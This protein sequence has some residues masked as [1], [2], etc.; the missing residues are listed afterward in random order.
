[1][2]AGKDSKGVKG[3]R[4]G[5]LGGGGGS[6][7]E[8]GFGG[9]TGERVQKR[10]PKGLGKECRWVVDKARCTLLE[11]SLGM[12]S[13][14]SSEDSNKGCRQTSTTPHNIIPG[15][16][17]PL[18]VGQ[19]MVQPQLWQA[20]QLWRTLQQHPAR[21]SSTAVSKKRKGKDG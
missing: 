18:H 14:L 17:P 21:H 2:S 5:S 13:R 9:V 3:R 8:G 10:G 19:Q 1:M 12:A 16:S 7:A 15:L 11:Q 6:D 4:T 20:V